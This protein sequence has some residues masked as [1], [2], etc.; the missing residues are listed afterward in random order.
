MQLQKMKYNFD[1]LYNQNDFIIFLQFKP[2]VYK[3]YAN[4]H[5]G[6]FMDN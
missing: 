6:I 5:D 1:K 3:L 2:I 4:K